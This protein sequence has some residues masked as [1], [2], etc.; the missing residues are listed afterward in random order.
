MRALL[1]DRL[2]SRFFNCFRLL[3]IAFLTHHLV[4]VLFMSSKG[5]IMIPLKCKFKC[6]AHSRAG[7]LRWIDW[8]VLE[9]PTERLRNTRSMHSRQVGVEGCIVLQRVVLHPPISLLY[10]QTIV[11]GCKL[12]RHICHAHKLVKSRPT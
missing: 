9:W 7:G 1:V 5:M 12:T 3:L 10:L 2:P 6:V 4:H 11:D 8:P